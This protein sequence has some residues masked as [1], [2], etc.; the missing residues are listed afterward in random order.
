MLGSSDE[1]GDGD[2][3][4]RDDEDGDVDAGYCGQYVGGVGYM[5]L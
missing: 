2:D 3:D 4:D 5:V 1:V